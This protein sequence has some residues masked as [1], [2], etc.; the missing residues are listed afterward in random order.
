LSPDDKV[1]WNE[2]ILKK[3]EQLEDLHKDL[4]KA[5]KKRS[6]L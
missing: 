3:E 4:D 2:K 6:K 5:E 1:K